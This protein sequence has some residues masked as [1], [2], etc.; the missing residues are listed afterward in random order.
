MRVFKVNPWAVGATTIVAIAVGVATGVG[1]APTPQATLTAADAADNDSLGRASAIDGDTV[2]VGAYRRN[3]YAGGAYVFTRS[4]TTWSQQQALAPGDLVSQDEYG[5]SVAVSGDTAAVGALVQNTSAGGVY[6]F[7]RSGTT[8]TQQ[9]KL[10]GDDTVSGDV[11]GRSVAL[12]GDTLVVGASNKD[13]QRGAV[14]VYTRSGTT[15]TQQQ[16]LAAQDAAAGD[17][18]GISVAIS[19]DTAAIGSFEA[20]GGKGAVYVFTRSGT[21]WTQQQRLS[22]PGG[23]TNDNFGN[24]VALS[25]DTAIVGAYNVGA[26]YAFMRSGTTWTQQQKLDSVGSGPGS[27]YGSSVAVDG[28]TAVIGAPL[29]AGHGGGYVFT[30][31]GTTWT[32]QPAL[33]I[34][35]GGAV[36]ELGD[37][38]GISGDTVVVG[39]EGRSNGQG[40]AYVFL[41]SAGPAAPSAG[42]CLPEKAKSTANS[43]QPMKSRL[44]A[45]GVLDAG[46]GVPD[47]SGAATF[48]V[49]G[50]HLAIPA[51]VAKGKSLTYGAGGISLTITPS[52][53]DSSRAT[54]S[55]SAVGDPTGK[56]DPN[57]PLAFHFKN[58]FHDLS[59]SASLTK[60]SLGPHAVTAPTLSVLKAA[61]TIKGGGKDALNLTLGFATDGTVPSAAEGLTIAFGGTFTAPLAAATFV[62][63]GD[64][65]VHTAKAPGIAKATIDY[66]KG[67]ITIVGAGLDLGAFA[68]GGN[69]VSVAVTRGADVRS[70]TIRMV[71]A[72]AK[73]SY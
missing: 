46:P 4:G 39:A 23:S 5:W 22:V 6:V 72:G 18:F 3:V 40:R 34:A 51:F 9:Q 2:V 63:K 68:P 58:A 1:A 60:G 29:G 37:S 55:V 24:A 47:F 65:W 57:G 50:F 32:E 53:I 12:D 52:K 73:L 62:R 45:S 8:W 31:T 16:K 66:V 48:D 27:L 38:V 64:S 26:A 17:S 69:V 61:A 43:R 36:D 67:T 56:I 19:G 33:A 30:R 20:D 44:A 25:G 54:F 15:W 35:D 7:T 21:T 14:Y 41:V 28:D 11:F 71:R 59:G 70:A 49:G 42:Y 10:A 13:F